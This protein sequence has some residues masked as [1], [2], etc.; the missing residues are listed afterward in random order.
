MSDDKDYDPVS[1]RMRAEEE[2]AK[3]ESRQLKREEKER[4]RIE[5]EHADEGK[6]DGQY[7]KLHYLL[8]RS[9][10]FAS[11]M[12]KKME[13]QELKNQQ[14][15]EREKKRLAKQE[16][17][18]EEVAVESQRKSTRAAATIGASDEKSNDVDS[19]AN[20][21]SK[22]LPTRGSKKQQQQQSNGDIGKFLTK[23]ELEERGGG[24]SVAE[25]MGEAA[26][27]HSVK[28]TAIGFQELRS[29][30]QPSAVT[31]GV[32]RSYQLEGLYW[33]TSLYENGLNGI[34]AD[35]MGLGKTIQTIAFLAF[36]R[37]KGINGP[38]LIVAPLSTLSNWIEELAK[39]TPTISSVLYHGSPA[40]RQELRETRM[41]IER[42]PKFPII[43]TSYEICMNDRKFL[44]NYGWKY[45]IIDE[46][47]RLKNLNC[48]LIQELK[49]Y[50]S[51]NRLLITGTPLQNNLAELWSLL[52]FLMPE[53]FDTL[54]NFESF[55][56][57]S[58]VLEKGGHKEIIMRER[59]N[60]LVA[61]LHA[62]LKPFL[63]RRIKTDVETQLPK[64]REYILYAPMTAPQKELYRQIIEGNSRAYLEQQVVDGL[65]EK[66]NGKPTKGTR[67]HN[68][69]RKAEAESRSST[70]N[71]SAK[72][73]RAS[74]PASIR[75]VRSTRSAV[76]G[77]GSYKEVSDR[78]YFQELEQESTSDDDSDS[79]PDSEEQEEIERA[80]TI[81]LAKKQIAGKK[82]QNPIMQLRLACNSPHN[83]YWPFG[84]DS[85]PDKSLITSSGKLLILERLL[86]H[87]FS[88]NHKVLIFSQFKT[89]LDILEDWASLMHD[90]HVCRID[91]GVAHEDRRR[92]I[93]EFNTDPSCKL[94]L[95]ST[96]AGGQ[97][98]NLA[99]AD[100]VIL[101]DSDWNPQQDLQAQD[102]AHR[103]GQTRPV[104]VYRLATKGTV[105]QTLLEKADGKR[106]L[107][108]LVIQKGKF[109]SLKR[110]LSNGN[111]EDD[112]DELARL[113]EENDGEGW[114][115]A[116]GE[117]GEKVLSDADLRT[118]CD[119]SPEAYEMAER[120][121]GEGEKF[122]NVETKREGDGILGEVKE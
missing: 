120:G 102:R 5:W 103:I 51:A 2:K 37:E 25:A 26:E 71:K 91:G 76:K 77:K 79:T 114:E 31:G 86:P 109:R 69:K 110:A 48:R 117:I 60:S 96:R 42:D 8:D 58:A 59:K 34:L 22:K 23:K 122:R 6:F 50:R 107:E 95:L 18:A 9:K 46:G 17:D 83:F 98:I 57:F 32:M 10:I 12:Q 121:E 45:I 104:I 55:F 87:L 78:Q 20:G 62:I 68:L 81:A 56:D 67:S 119:R 3:T 1:E 73:S 49:M 108:K 54:E 74:T 43:C 118:L 94:F 4:A 111:A 80:E 33:L 41:K 36:L 27:E 75:S 92:Q 70:P 19:K 99:S 30:N 24:K 40:E 100:T 105:E 115:A 11:I 47:H 89:T 44:A 13:A 116:E 93:K 16:A 61:S 72:T 29:A 63:L 35:E 106:R 39:W 113:L 112:V 14:S 84:E 21:K 53:V 82:L 64:K 52:N 65:E 38:F 15:D 97:G 101:F 85:R 66:K 90:W 28:S 88:L 7:K